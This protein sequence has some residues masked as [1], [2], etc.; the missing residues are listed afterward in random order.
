MAIA[1]L[2]L[3]GMI[4]VSLNGTAFAVSLVSSGSAPGY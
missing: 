2:V 1:A 4:D 3:V